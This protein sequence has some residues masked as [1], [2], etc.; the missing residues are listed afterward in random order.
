MVI[1][2]WL[3]VLIMVINGDSMDSYTIV[4]DGA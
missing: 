1:N 3:V 4:I 2:G